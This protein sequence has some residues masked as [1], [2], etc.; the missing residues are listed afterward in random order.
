ML[1]QTDGNIRIK[2]Q[3]RQK[4]MQLTTYRDAIT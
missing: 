2:R 3:H 4:I 1:L